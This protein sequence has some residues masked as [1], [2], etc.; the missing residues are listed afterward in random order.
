MIIALTGKLGSGKTTVANIFESLGANIISADKLGH[1]L[2]TK[3]NIKK[4]LVEN[5]GE[6]ILES[7]NINRKKLA[8]VVF[9]DLDNLK[10]LNSI[11]H[12]LLKRKILE[13]IK[14]GLNIIDAALYYK[15][16]LETVSDK[17]I[18][19][20]CTEDKVL[21]RLNDISLVSRRSFQKQIKNPDYIINNNNTPENTKEQVIK[22]WGKLNESSLSRNI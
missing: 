22:I 20:E 5:F 18:L 17:T 15:L 7:N 10:T 1:E 11:I 9:N 16:E 2:L 14:P 4:K 12:P 13:N 19:V 3:E 8:E 21:K 6:D